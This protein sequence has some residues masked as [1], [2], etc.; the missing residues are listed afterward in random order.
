MAYDDIL[1]KTTLEQRLA[2][3]EGFE[4]L[5][6]NPQVYGLIK[7]KCLKV[8]NK[9][10]EILHQPRSNSNV[11]VFLSATDFNL[12]AMQNCRSLYKIGI[13]VKQVE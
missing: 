2:Q 3:P 6:T 1:M 11:Y 5:I 9:G 8:T 7:I 12:Y 4:I 10:L 13:S